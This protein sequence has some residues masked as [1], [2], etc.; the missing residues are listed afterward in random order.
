MGEKRQI[1]HAEELQII[2][3]DT[4]S[5]K[6]VSLAPDPFFIVTSLWR[7]QYGKGKMSNYRGETL[8]TLPE[9]SGQH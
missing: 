2:Y 7:E 5:S 3:V 6:K 4:S 1:S 8:Q 9:P